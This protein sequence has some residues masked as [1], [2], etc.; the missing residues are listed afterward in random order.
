MP[1]VA[2]KVFYLSLVLS[3]DSDETWCSFFHVYLAWDSLN[4]LYLFIYSFYQIWKILA[5]VSS[6]I[7]IFLSFLAL[8]TPIKHIL[9]C[10]KLFHSSLVL[11]SFLKVF[12]YFILNAFY[13]YFFKF[14]NLLFYKVLLIIPVPSVCFSSQ[15][16]YFSS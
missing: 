16:L 13:H 8:E 6:Y 9:S 3:T 14:I 5:I 7:Y 15:K 2:L 12:V 1:L 4:F 11:C 10:L